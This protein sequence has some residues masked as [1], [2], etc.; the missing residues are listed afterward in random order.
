MPAGQIGAG[1]QPIA[2][3]RGAVPVPG[4]GMRRGIG[5]A[6]GA[7]A[8][9]RPM[10]AVSG[11][12]FNSNKIGAISGIDSGINSITLEPKIETEEEK[13]KNLEK[14]V[15]QLAEESCTAYEM[16]E[17]QTVNKNFLSLL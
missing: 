6:Q 9:G 17:K 11:A 1:K 13:L 4:T 3:G 5:T 16:N 10:T 14:S 8:G 15:S 7:A 12:G 2:L